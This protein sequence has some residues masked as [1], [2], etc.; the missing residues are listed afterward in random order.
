MRKGR[1]LCPALALD[2]LDRL[3]RYSG[4]GAKMR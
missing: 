2:K 1:T 4:I 3:P